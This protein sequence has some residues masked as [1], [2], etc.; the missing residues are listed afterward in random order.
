M[1]P[2]PIA[3]TT[4]SKALAL[5]EQY[6][7]DNANV[8]LSSLSVDDVPIPTLSVIQ[9]GSKMR[10][11]D[12]RPFT[13]GRLYYKALQTDFEIVECN[14]LVI[15]KKDMPSYTDHT[16]LERTYMFLG[17]MKPND[18]PFLMFNKSSSYFAARQFIGTV[19]ARKYPMYALQVQISTE[20]RQNDMGEWFVPVFTIVGVESNPDRIIN[21]ENLAKDYDMNQEAIRSEEEQPQVVNSQ[22]AEETVT[23]ETV[24]TGEVVDPDQ[25]V[26]PDEIPF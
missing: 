22:Q 9:S 15:T 14:I 2:K 12:G 18:T 1:S 21:L 24:E 11:N 23:E 16:K 8:G 4:E 25:V 5:P 17:V 6:F 19:K 20:K 13:P 7:A 26:N 3:K 10:D